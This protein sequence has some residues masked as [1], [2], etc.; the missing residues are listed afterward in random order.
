MNVPV[1]G[2]HVHFGNSLQIPNRSIDDQSARVGCFERVVE[3]VVADNRTAFLFSEKIDDEDIAGLQ[4]IWNGTTASA[5]FSAGAQVVGGKVV[6]DFSGG[7]GFIKSILSGV[8]LENDFTIGLGY[9]AGHGLHFEGSDARSVS[10]PRWEGKS[11]SGTDYFVEQAM[12]NFFFH[13]SIAYALLR[14]NGVD[15]GKRDYIGQLSFRRPA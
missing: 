1:I 11:L 14:H 5:A 13:Y 9:T 8:H 12:P 3:E 15:L 2:G 10:R 4:L 7:D 6:I